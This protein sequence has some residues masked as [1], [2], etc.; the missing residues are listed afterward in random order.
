MI[1]DG[2]ARGEAILSVVGGL[3][4][5]PGRRNLRTVAVGVV[6]IA[7]GCRAA[8]IDGDQAARGIVAIVPGRSRAAEGLRCIRDPAQ[9]VA[10]VRL[11]HQRAAGTAGGVLRQFAEAVVS[12]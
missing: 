11:R 6:G 4:G 1:R 10:R 5:R 3:F 7:G 8:F 9:F 12:E 2:A